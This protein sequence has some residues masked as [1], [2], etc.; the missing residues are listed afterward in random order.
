MYVV[1]KN[2]TLQ[3]EDNTF[4]DAINTYK[5]VPLEIIDSSRKEE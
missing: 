4:A 2:T 5:Q 3:Q 1:V